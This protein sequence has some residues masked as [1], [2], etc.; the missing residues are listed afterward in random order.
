MKMMLSSKSSNLIYFSYAAFLAMLLI[1]NIAWLTNLSLKKEL[2]VVHDRNTVYIKDFIQYYRDSKIATSEEHNKIYNRQTRLK[3]LNELIKPEHVENP[4]LTQGPPLQILLFLPLSFLPLDQAHFAWDIISMLLGLSALIALL[5][6]NLKSHPKLSLLIILG[7]FA[8]IPGINAL[9]LGQTSWYTLAMYGFYWWAWCQQR[10]K[11]AGV[12]LGL[13]IVKF[14]YAPFLLIAPL[15]KKKYGLLLIAFLTIA[16]SFITTGAFFGWEN[17][18]GYPLT[19]WHI[20]K[21]TNVNANEMIS[22]RA[23]FSLFFPLSLALFISIVLML[24][25]LAFLYRFWTKTDSQQNGFA[26]ALTTITALLT[27]AHTFSIDTIL[28]AIPAIL[29]LPQLLSSSVQ[30]RPART[31]YLLFFFYPLFTILSL[32]IFGNYSYW[33]YLVMNLILLSVTIQVYRCNNSKQIL[34][35]P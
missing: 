8:S 10:Y 5:G 23:F 33:T 12:F 14:Q 27:S 22:L 3:W 28:L 34:R 25:C 13:S 21:D 1:V 9:F 20:E 6:P 2:T 11:L 24:I 18:I 32:M 4:L 35:T 16:A 30:E 17:I 19:F 29:T 31:Y 15:A 7:T 26:I